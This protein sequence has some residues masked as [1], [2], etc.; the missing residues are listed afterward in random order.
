MHN[1]FGDDIQFKTIDQIGDPLVKLN[2]NIDWEIFR[3][4]IETNIHKD[5]SKGG[6]P[7]Y[8]AILMFKIVTL[9]QLYGLSDL[10]TQF[11]INN[12]HNFMRFLGLNQDIAPDCNTIWVFKEALKKTTL[13][14]HCLICSIKY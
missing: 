10:S 9:H 2:K 3:T 1:F 4:P 5:R 6:R 13:I 11:E 12:R 8:D 14:V 7:P